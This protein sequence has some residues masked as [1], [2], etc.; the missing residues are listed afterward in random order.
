MRE[1]EQVLPQ[2]RPD[3]VDV[4]VPVPVPSR[5]TV[6]A[7]ESSAKLAVTLRDWLIETVHDSDVPVHAPL[8]PANLEPVAGTAL[9]V[10]E[11]P[12]FRTLLQVLPQSMPAAPALTTPLPTPVLVTDS[13]YGMAVKVAVTL[14]ASLIVSVQAPVPVQAPLQPEKVEPMAVVGVSVTVV[15]SAY[16]WLQ[17]L[18]HWMPL[19]EDATLPLPVPLRVTFSA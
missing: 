17:S 1:T 10:T 14:R 5:A 9:S 18:P 7:N 8:Q 4:T 15:P 16:G 12:A 13:V 3:G 2:D 11:V 19:G 6:S